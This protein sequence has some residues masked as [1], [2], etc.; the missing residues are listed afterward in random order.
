MKFLKKLF[1]RKA[2]K[3]EKA[4]KP[5]KKEEAKPAEAPKE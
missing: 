4:P 1:R 2:K 5:E 3:E